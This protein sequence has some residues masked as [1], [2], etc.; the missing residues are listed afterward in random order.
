MHTSKSMFWVYAHLPNPISSTIGAFI[1]I[2]LLFISFRSRAIFAIIVDD[3]LFAGVCVCVRIQT[4]HC[5]QMTVPNGSRSPHSAACAGRVET[6]THTHNF[7][8]EKLPIAIIQP[9]L[10]WFSPMNRFVFIGQM[11]VV[12]LRHSALAPHYNRQRFPFRATLVA[13]MHAST[14][15]SV[16]KMHKQNDIHINFYL[17]AHIILFTWCALCGLHLPIAKTIT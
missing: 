8:C 9:F 6:Y 12:S 4:H 15:A 17:D 16:G 2:L 7:K 5:T 10:A 13:R 14:V 11:V 3:S 1:L